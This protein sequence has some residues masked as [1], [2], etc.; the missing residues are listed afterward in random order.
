LAI[1]CPAA[2]LAFTCTEMLIVTGWLFCAVTLH[3]TTLLAVLH[4]PLVAVA[5][6]T[7]RFPSIVSRTSIVLALALLLKTVSV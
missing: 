7:S 5:P 1:R 2:T 3:V 6:S 4:V